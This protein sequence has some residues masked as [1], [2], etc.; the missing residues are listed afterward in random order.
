[1]SY[2]CLQKIV[3]NTAIRAIFRS[4]YEKKVIEKYECI[5][6]GLF[7]LDP[8][9]IKQNKDT[10]AVSSLALAIHSCI[11]SFIHPLFMYNHRLYLLTISSLVRPVH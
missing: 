8:Q 11:H 10:F 3:C 7:H 2:V 9:K 4:H 5:P 6:V 1:M